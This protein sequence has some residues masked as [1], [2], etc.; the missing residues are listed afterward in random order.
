V[1]VVVVGG[2]LVV[3]VDVAAFWHPMIEVIKT[4]L[5]ITRRKPEYLLFIN[6][7]SF[8][9]SNLGFPIFIKKR[10]CKCRFFQ[11]LYGTVTHVLCPSLIISITSS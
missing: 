10:P 9:F 1:V 11:G 7:P 4:K 3:V 6:T 5:T 8:Y 2:L